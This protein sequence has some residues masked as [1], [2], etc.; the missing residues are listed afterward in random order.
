MD[1]VGHAG[2][3]TE[4]EPD[5]QDPADHKCI[6]D[7]CTDPPANKFWRHLHRI[8]QRKKERMSWRKFCKLI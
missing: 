1:E 5:D 6:D 4:P 7:I 2:P 8:L 3:A